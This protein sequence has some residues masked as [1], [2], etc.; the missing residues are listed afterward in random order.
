MFAFTAGVL[1]GHTPPWS[2]D[3]L[4]GLAEQRDEEMHRR[5]PVELPP[6]VDVAQRLLD[7]GG[8]TTLVCT[9]IDRA[10]KCSP[11][12]EE[13]MALEHRF[14]AAKLDDVDLQGVDPGPVACPI[15]DDDPGNRFI[16]T[17]YHGCE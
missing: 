8:P 17:L 13:V 3:D 1:L 14:A 9:A 11:G 5:Q 15:G 16:T 10:V 6:R 4:C 2:V 12:D 7:D